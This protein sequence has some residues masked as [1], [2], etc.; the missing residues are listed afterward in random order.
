[1]KIIRAGW[2]TAALIGLALGAALPGPAIGLDLIPVD[3]AQ[4]KAFGI[5]LAA[6]QAA[7]ETLTRRYPAKVTVPNRQMRVVSAPQGGILSALLVAEGEHVSAGQVLAEMKSPEL[8]DTQSQYLESVTRLALAES[9]LK[10]DEQLHREGVIAERRL[11]ESR[12]KQREL[13]TQVEQRRQLLGLAG[14][15]EEAIDSLTRTR[16]LGST[17]PVRAP[18]AGVVLEQLV[19]TGQAVAAAAPLYRVAELQPLWVEVHV[20]VDRVEA[21]KVGGRVLLRAIDTQGEIITIGRMVHEEDQG[22]LVRAEVTE[23]TERLR[24]SQFVEVQL[25]STTGETGWRVPAGAVVRNAGAAYLFVAREGGFAALPVTGVAE[26]E[27]S[28][29][30]AGEV[31]AKDQVAV[32]GVVALKAAW[33]GAAE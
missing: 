23:G 6:P 13:A 12:S 15:S 25:T 28:A 8:V 18:I 30:V 24:P 11:L 32:T 3:P 19:S 16:V 17:L 7:G 26:E 10:R 29:V 14:L 33:L 2:S 31:G 20:P 4:Q 1:M 27:R 21:L 5:E 22:V 9:E